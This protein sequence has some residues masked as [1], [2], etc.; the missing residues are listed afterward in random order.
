MTTTKH[1]VGLQKLQGIVKPLQ[2]HFPGTLKAFQIIKS[3]AYIF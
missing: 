3:A 1:L 2:A